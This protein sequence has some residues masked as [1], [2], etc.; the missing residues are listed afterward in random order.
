MEWLD[1][2][3]TR[4]RVFN[5]GLVR[6]KLAVIID[7]KISFDLM[8]GD[9]IFIL[10]GMVPIHRRDS[11]LFPKL[12]AIN[13]DCCKWAPLIITSVVEEYP[14]YNSVLLSAGDKIEVNSI[15]INRLREMM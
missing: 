2:G 10:S 6:L 8:D 1:F 11:C 5:Y 7:G 3:Q 12:I 14:V 15:I 13:H 9:P 4:G